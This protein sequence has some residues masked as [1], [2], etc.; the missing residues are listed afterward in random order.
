[1]TDSMMLFFRFIP[2]IIDQQSINQF[3]EIIFNATLYYAL[4]IATPLYIFSRWFNIIF[5]LI[6]IIT[7]VN[8]Y[9]SFVFIIGVLYYMTTLTF[10]I[11]WFININIFGFINIKCG[12][13]VFKLIFS[14]CPS[15]INKGEL[16]VSLKYGYFT[17]HELFE[18]ILW[19]Y[20]THKYAQI[21]G[22]IVMDIVGRDLAT[23]IFD[24][25][26]KSYPQE[27]HLC[28]SLDQ[29]NEKKMKRD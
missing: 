1:M 26:P 7:M 28:G 22:K 11:T 23:K 24:Y 3:C 21:K 20:N 9:L 14:L 5:P 18:R 27:K 25:F 13:D 6:V 4:W 19:H 8:N 29:K 16:Y 2:N 15:L 12:Y 10:L 17:Q